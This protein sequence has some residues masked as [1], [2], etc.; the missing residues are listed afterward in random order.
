MEILLENLPRFLELQVSNIDRWE[1]ERSGALLHV[2]AV[3]NAEL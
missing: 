1:Y 3:G 2:K